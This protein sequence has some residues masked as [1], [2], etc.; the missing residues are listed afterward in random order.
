VTLLVL[1]RHQDVV[2][3]FHADGAPKVTHLISAQRER[4]D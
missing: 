4:D 2:R 1:Q 3:R